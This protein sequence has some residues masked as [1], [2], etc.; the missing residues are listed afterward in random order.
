MTDLLLA[1]AVQKSTAEVCIWGPWGLVSLFGQGSRSSLL[2]QPHHSPRGT[3]TH[4]FSRPSLAEGPT[5]CPSMATVPP[6]GTRRLSRRQRRMAPIVPFWATPPIFNNSQLY[7]LHRTRTAVCE[8]RKRN[9]VLPHYPGSL[10][11]LNHGWLG[12]G[13][14]TRGGVNAWT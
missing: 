6:T 14:E 7:P 13:S 11:P 3:L 8:W 9:Y 1:Q 12:W 4:C 10:H 5:T 2:T